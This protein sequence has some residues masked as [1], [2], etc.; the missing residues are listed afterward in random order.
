MEKQEYNVHLMKLSQLEQLYREFKKI[1]ADEAG[2]RLM[3]P[4]AEMKIIKLQNVSLRAANLL[5]QEMLAKGGDAVVH[6]DVSS[7][8]KDLSDMILIGTRRQLWAVINTLKV[9]PFGLKKIGEEI[10]QILLKE[11]RNEKER[12]LDCKG[13]PLMIG[14]KTLVMGILNVTPDSFSDGGRFIDMDQAIEHAKNL[15]ANGADIVDIG[16]ESTRPGHQVISEQEE[17]NR[18]I[19]IIQRLSKEITVPI[20]IDTYKAGVAKKAIEAGAHII[21]DIWGFKKDKK[22]PKVAAELDVPVILMHNRSDTNYKSFMDDVINDLKESI[23]IAIEAG[24]KEKNIILDPGIGFARNYEQ[25]L[26]TMN[27]LDEIVSLG[28]PVLLGTSRKSMIGTALNLPVDDRVEGTA[29][30][31]AL[32]IVKGCKIIRVHDV[33]EMSRVAKMV[34]A[35]IYLPEEQVLMR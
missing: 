16:G 4:K 23:N 34:D 17:L 14:R 5:K 7:L 28:Y 22:M 15:V 29:A 31:V 8:K 18:V 26:I 1:G 27:R 11:E 13:I 33:K 2:I 25:N 10:R 6:R 30:T 32:G 3:I 9:Q 20:S 12:F 35:M 21:N 19:P 24:V